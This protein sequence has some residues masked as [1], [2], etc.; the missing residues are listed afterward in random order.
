MA[1]GQQFCPACGAQVADNTGLIAGRVQNHIQL[2][3]I[4]WFVYS[5]F[6]FVAGAAAVI[7]SKTLFV[8]LARRN[9]NFPGFI[10]PLVIAAGCLILIK[11][12]VGFAAAWGLLQREPWA[13]ML[14]LV[15]AF[16][17]LLNPPFGSA[18]G[19]Y[20]LWVLLPGNAAADYDRL[21]PRPASDGPVPATSQR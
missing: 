18:L 12:F 3:S 16:V 4:L 1:A 9:D 11:A 6:T 5:F 15:L 13:R 2:V 14:T 21:S 20:T 17:S 10:Q 19:I 8:E 7:V